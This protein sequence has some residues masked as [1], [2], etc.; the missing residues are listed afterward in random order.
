[1]TA[2]PRALAPWATELSVFPDDVGLALGHLATRLALAVGPLSTQSPSLAGEPDGFD[3]ITRRG[4]YVH[5]L[6][7][8]WALADAFPDEFLRRA[9]SG[10][11]A[12]LR[13]HR[14]ESAMGRVALALFDAGPSQIGGP[15]IV[16]LATLIV[17]SQRA[18]AS[19]VRFRWGIVQRPEDGWIDD[20]TPPTVGRLLKARTAAVPRTEHLRRWATDMEG[21]GVVGDL[22][23]VGTPGLA[24]LAPE[25]RPAV[26]AIDDPLEP[27]ACALE[28]TCTRFR[29]PNAR[30]TLE[31][32]EGR[33]SVRLLRDP[34]EIATAP[35]LRSPL[36][37]RPKLTL[38]SGAR[39][40]IIKRAD[41]KL[42]LFAVPNSAQAPGSRITTFSPPEG[43]TPIA[44]DWQ[45]GRW[46]ILTQR[47]GALVLH[48][49][50]KGGGPVRPPLLADIVRPLPAPD[51]GGGLATLVRRRDGVEC[52]VHPS[53][54][55][56]ELRNKLV[57]LVG[58]ASAVG[59]AGW[60]VLW[61]REEGKARWLE[62]SGKRR[63]LDP[64]GDGKSFFGWQGSSS[65]DWLLALRVQLGHWKIHSETISLTLT[66]PAETQVLGVTHGPALILCESDRRSLTLWG[67]HSN[68]KLPPLTDALA[69]A[70]ACAS[71]PY[72]AYS[73]V[74]GELIVYSLQRR[75]T[76]LHV[77]PDGERSS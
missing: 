42:S 29:R 55:G 4:A 47:A 15:R 40:V 36:G 34:F 13:V 21:A 30:V 73:S 37:P 11:L 56:V 41:G 2:L 27:G 46:R 3:G 6:P 63:E 44:T 54:M 69:E 75:A 1:M 9:S 66:A 7:S 33:M 60:D 25:L 19:R 52:F 64:S 8:E 26:I 77:L 45:I 32:P 14:R 58:P 16:Q 20:V 68:A 24:V 43:E 31:L 39:K 74:T 23:L 71:A 51:P 10:E 12:F 72:V 61:V 50:A 62:R 38:S 5:L 57:Y 28:V 53:G 67:L 76:V 65:D 35:P 70:C 48:T 22:W 59:R 17:L 49:I 18:R